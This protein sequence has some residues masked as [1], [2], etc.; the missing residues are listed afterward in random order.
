VGRL[1]EPDASPVPSAS[2]ETSHV[3]TAA[4][5]VALFAQHAGASATPV[6]VVADVSVDASGP[7]ASPVCKQGKA[8]PYP[9]GAIK[10]LGGA[11][12]FALPKE[13]YPELTFADLSAPVAL[14]LGVDH[15][16]TFLGHV[17][18]G[19]DLGSTWSVAAA[20]GATASFP[21]GTVVAAEGWL[22]TLAGLNGPMM[23]PDRLPPFDT[24]WPDVLAPT[25]DD[26]APEPSWESSASVIRVEQGAYVTFGPGERP[27]GSPSEFGTYLIEHV[28]QQTPDC[29]SCDGWLMVGRLPS[30][31]QP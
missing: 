10:E 30:A 27:P 24:A 19:G 22:S 1:D 21:L 15:A 18:I 20:G 12:A 9:V 3:L 23:P 14:R 5:L 16:I 11:T 25:S 28:A 29:S 31:P 6:D 13:L 2:P 8:C 26:P 7:F 4:D 17:D